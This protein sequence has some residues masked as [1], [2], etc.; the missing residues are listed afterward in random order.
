M[1]QKIDPCATHSMALRGCLEARVLDLLSLKAR[2]ELGDLN[3]WH[4]SQFDL[5]LTREKDKY[6]IIEPAGC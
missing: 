3:P 4:A 5:K 2:A 1:T 6:Q